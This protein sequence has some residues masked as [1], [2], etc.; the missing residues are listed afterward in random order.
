M[1]AQVQVPRPAY[2][3]YVAP[4]APKMSPLELAQHQLGLPEGWEVRIAR[5]SG[6]AYY[7]HKV[8][9][10]SQWEK[11]VGQASNEA[12]RFSAGDV[13]V[14]EGMK[15]KPEL[16]GCQARVGSF[17]AARGRHLVEL[18]SDGAQLSIKPSNAQLAQ[19]LGRFSAGDVVVIEGLVGKPELNGCQARVG[20]F[21]AARGRY[22]VEL[23]KDGSQLAVK[24]TNA[25]LVP[26]GQPAP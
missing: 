7:F 19:P 10:K 22:N 20:T 3:P 26:P 5:S 18:L 8:T 17:D 12:P 11:P 21:D 4:P 24:P 23:L 25:V 16:N 9:Q 15:S 2:T 14:I 1:L 6:E 13:V